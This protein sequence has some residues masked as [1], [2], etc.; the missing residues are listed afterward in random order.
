MHQLWQIHLGNY[1]SS[2]ADP[3][4]LKGFCFSTKA[5]QTVVNVVPNTM[6]RLERWLAPECKHN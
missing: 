1:Q 4:L 5:V 3:H 6:E 2:I